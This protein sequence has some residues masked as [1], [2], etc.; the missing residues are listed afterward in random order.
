MSLARVGDFTGAE[1]AFQA[2]ANEKG[3]V[4]ALKLDYAKFLVDQN[5]PVDA[6]H[7]VHEIVA[8]D[9]HSVAAWRLGG[10]IALSRAEFLEVAC[11]WTAEAMKQLPQ[12]DQVAAQRAEALMLSQQT[13][14]ARVLWER[15][16]KSGRQP[17]SLA[18]LILCE[19]VADGL[20]S[21]S[22]D[23]EPEL[24]PTSRAVIEWYR[25][26]LAVRAQ[27]MLDRLNQQTEALRSILP[28]AVDMI[29]AAL[30]EAGEQPARALEPCLA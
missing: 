2:G 11:D 15:L 8:Q 28:A 24:G 12:D 14:A 27:G 21:R 1:K 20:S 5:R 23:Y 18:A 29:D 17:R 16:W 6:L 19:I 13:A 26:C 4:D 9:A 22:A 3:P 7:L 30:A 10:E 25:R